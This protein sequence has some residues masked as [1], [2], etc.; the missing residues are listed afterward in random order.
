MCLFIMIFIRVDFSVIEIP[1]FWIKIYVVSTKNIPF[2][3][4]GCRCHL[5]P[6][7]INYAK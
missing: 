3:I 2:M 5:G 1:V 4:C 7:G 6:T